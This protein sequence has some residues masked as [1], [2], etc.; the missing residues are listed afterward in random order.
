MVSGQRLTEK[1]CK[2]NFLNKNA[3]PWAAFSIKSICLGQMV[4]I[5]VR[6]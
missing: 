4:S 1:I 2:Q 5:S 3:A 6:R